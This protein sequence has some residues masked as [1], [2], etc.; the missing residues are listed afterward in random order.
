MDDEEAGDGGHD[1]KEDEEEEEEDAGADDGA[2]GKGKRPPDS[3][4]VQRKSARGGASNAGGANK[5]DSD[6]KSAVSMIMTIG[7]L[8]LFAVVVLGVVGFI[9]FKITQSEDSEPTEGTTAGAG[10]TTEALG[11]NGSL[12]EGGVSVVSFF[13]KIAAQKV[14]RVAHSGAQQF[15][16]FAEAPEILNEVPASMNN[17]TGGSNSRLDVLDNL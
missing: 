6:A 16:V 4:M 10:S 9:I 8:V 1:K 11:G 12:D 13:N 15:L 3:I 14:R 2:P 7:G 17:Y 5:S